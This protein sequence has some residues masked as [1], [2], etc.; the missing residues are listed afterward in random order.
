M[1]VVSIQILAAECEWLMFLVCGFGQARLRIT[2]SAVGLRP[3]QYLIDTCST[4]NAIEIG[5][6]LV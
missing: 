4:K 5:D 2:S 1:T 6:G 3:V